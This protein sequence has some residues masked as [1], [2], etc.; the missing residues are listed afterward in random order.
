MLTEIEATYGSNIYIYIYK[1]TDIHGLLVPHVHANIMDITTNEGKSTPLELIPAT[2]TLKFS[3][4]LHVDAPEG[5]STN[6]QHQ[7][8]LSL[9]TL[10]STKN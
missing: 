5:V 10:T 1:H 7:I 8:R 9:D 3:G 4:I 2:L 6:N